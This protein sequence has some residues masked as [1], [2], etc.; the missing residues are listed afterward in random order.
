MLDLL[1]LEEPQASIHAVRQAGAEERML[2]DARLRVGA[3]EERHVGERHALAVQRLDLVDDEARLLLVVR[4]CI[5]TQRLTLAFGGP[6]VLAESRLVLSDD[7]VG[8]V[9]DVPL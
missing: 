5:D 4:R 8:G 3:V 7:R 9:E 6:Q 2:E 1:A